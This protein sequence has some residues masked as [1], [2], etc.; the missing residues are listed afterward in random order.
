M[1]NTQLKGKNGKIEI[2]RESEV[3]S[4]IH[5]ERRGRRGG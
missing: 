5:E 2:K 3:G 4:I 1:E